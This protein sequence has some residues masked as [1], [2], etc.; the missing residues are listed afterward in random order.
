[1]KANIF[2]AMLVLLVAGVSGCTTTGNFV[3]PENSKLYLYDRSTPETVSETGTVETRPFFWTAAGGVPYK[4]KQDG[5][6]VK[7]GKLRSKFRVVSIFWPPYAIF[8]WPIGLNPRVV[9]DLV[10]DTQE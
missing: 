4:V 6:T 3:M 8:Y 10:N 9:Y 7:E 2:A 5:K 1:M